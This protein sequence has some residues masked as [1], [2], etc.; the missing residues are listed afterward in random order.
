MTRLV[1][2]FAITDA[3]MTSNAVEA[4]P[5]WNGDTAYVVGDSVALGHRL[6]EAALP[7]AGNNPTAPIVGGIV[8]WIDTGPTNTWAAFDNQTMTQTTATDELVIT[9]Q[10][11]GRA[12]S[13]G[14]LNINAAA[15]NVTVR[16]GGEVA[17]SQ[18]FS[19]VST[20]GIY[21][22][23]TYLFEPIERATTFVSTALPNSY[24]PEITITLTG[25]GEVGVG[26]VTLG[27][28]FD[29][30]KTLYPAELDFQSYSEF[31]EDGFGVITGIIKR[32]YRDRGRFN[33]WVED[34]RVSSVSRIL[35][36]YNAVPVL[37]IASEKYDATIYFGLLTNSRVVLSR[38]NET[39]LA[40]DVD[41]F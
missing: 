40:F 15:G 19:L 36:D 31:E 26:Q 4:T 14:L 33:V 11:A 35:R 37:I 34:D 6:Y 23:S 32:G 2:P 30:G 1:R 24:N 10:V 5:L 20:A 21:D 18:D 29:L 17:F 16:V 7:S 12:D 39:Q 38:W 41:G 25:D 3:N 27:Y 22:W 28:A 13:I 9:I 8:Y